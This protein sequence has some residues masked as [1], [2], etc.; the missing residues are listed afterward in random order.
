MNMPA[1]TLTMGADDDAFMKTH[2]S[3]SHS[4]GG[5]KHRYELHPQQRPSDDKVDFNDRLYVS[6]GLSELRRGH[7]ASQKQNNTAGAYF[8]SSMARSHSQ[9]NV[10]HN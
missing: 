6:D 5:P 1:R 3:R 10:R 7:E 2:A 4:T 9:S 8:T